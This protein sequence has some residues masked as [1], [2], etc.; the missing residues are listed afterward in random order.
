ML[1]LKRL[2][3]VSR[4]FSTRLAFS[5]FL[6]FLMSRDA[7]TIILFLHFAGWTT[8]SFAAAD[9]E[10]GASEADSLNR[11]VVELY[12]AG[13]YQEAIPLARQLLEITE[14]LNGL[15]HGDTVASLNNLV[16]CNISSFIK[17][18]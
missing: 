9:G 5:R 16:C 3:P 1:S 18:W 4:L 13:K 10:G 11:Q 6:S 12:G 15:E 2:V 17:Y 14:K 8:A 7:L